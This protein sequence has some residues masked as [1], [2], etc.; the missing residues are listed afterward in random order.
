MVVLVSCTSNKLNMQQQKEIEHVHISGT[1]KI[2]HDEMLTKEEVELLNNLLKN[3]R[4]TFDFHKKKVAFITGS[5]GS[6]FLSKADC[7]GQIKRWLDSGDIPSVFM[8]LLTEEDK[9]KS[10]GYDAFVLLWVKV[11]SN[12]QKKRMIERLAV[13]IIYTSGD[14]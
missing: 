11:L 9:Y 10:G 5:A 14:Y 12:R 4:D 7:F 3:Q 2:D 8:V 6:R 13:Q 1:H